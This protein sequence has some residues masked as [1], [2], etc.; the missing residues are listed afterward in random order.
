[1][2]FARCTAFA[3]LAFIFADNTAD[4]ILAFHC[5]VKAASRNRAVVFADNTADAASAAAGRYVPLDLEVFHNAALR[6]IAE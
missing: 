2:N 5:T 1:M 6:N 3:H 4:R